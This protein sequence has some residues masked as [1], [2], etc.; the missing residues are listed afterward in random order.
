MAITTA[1]IAEQIR[2]ILNPNWTIHVDEIRSYQI[3]SAPQMRRAKNDVDFRVWVNIYRPVY[4][5]VFMRANT[6]PQLRKKIDAGELWDAICRE[7]QEKAVKMSPEELEKLGVRRT[8]LG[9]RQLRL[10]HQQ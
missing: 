4:I 7:F 8:G 2:G 9:Q 10:E 5:S 1:D 6:L 3:P